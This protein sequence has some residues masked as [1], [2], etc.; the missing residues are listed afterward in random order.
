MIKDR[1]GQFEEAEYHRARRSGSYNYSRSF[2][3]HCRNHVSGLQLSSRI[4][5]R[6]VQEDVKSPLKNWW[7]DYRKAYI[8]SVLPHDLILP[9]NLVVQHQVVRQNQVVRQA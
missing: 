1:L 8:S 3:M 7:Q 5:S 6:G 4:S 2:Q 9:Y